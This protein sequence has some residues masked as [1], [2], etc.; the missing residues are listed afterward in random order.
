MDERAKGARADVLRPNEPQPIEALRVG[1]PDPFRRA[2]QFQLLCP[3]LVS[4]PC[5]SRSRLARCFTQRSAAST[6]KTSAAAGRPSQKY[7]ASGASTLAAKAAA[8]E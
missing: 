7:S 8:E 2:L 4:V 5:T 3:I 6:A 1:E